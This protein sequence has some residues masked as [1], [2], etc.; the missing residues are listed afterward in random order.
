MKLK[1]RH[2]AQAKI[3]HLPRRNTVARARPQLQFDEPEGVSPIMDLQPSQLREL[4]LL[5]GDEDVAQRVIDL[6]QKFPL[7]SLPEL[8]VYDWLSRE[9][10]QFVFQGEF[11]GG[12]TI[13]GGAVPDFVV[14]W[15]GKGLVL[16]VQG[17][18]WHTLPGQVEKDL[19]QKMQMMGQY[20]NGLRVA[21][22][23][24]VWENDIYKRRE[25]TM[26]MAIAGIELR[27]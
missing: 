16:R 7:A 19:G 14:N 13:H 1:A 3:K 6:A 12:R 9:E 27:A 21:A 8:V 4:T 26:Q 15:G 25:H 10:Y 23:V 22:I 11:G 18:Y 2:H 24:D 20:V 17:E 5:L